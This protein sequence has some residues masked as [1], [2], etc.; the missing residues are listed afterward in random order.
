MSERDG[1]RGKKKERED[2]EVEKRTL[3]MKKWV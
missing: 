1:G 2:T 3:L